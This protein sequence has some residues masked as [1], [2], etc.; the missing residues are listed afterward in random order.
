MA[1]L[2]RLERG[3]AIA[4]NW[5]SK[6]QLNVARTVA[7]AKASGQPDI[8]KYFSPADQDHLGRDQHVAEVD[9]SA[10]SPATKAARPCWPRWRAS[11]PPTWRCAT[12]LF[13]HVKQADAPAAEALLT[14]KMLPASE[15]YLAAMAAVQDHQ[16]ELAAVGGAIA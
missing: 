10:R 7:I 13:E 3:A 4:R 8:E 11:A 5:V 16:I 1:E 12:R 2:D 9:G 15:A 14:N 6:T